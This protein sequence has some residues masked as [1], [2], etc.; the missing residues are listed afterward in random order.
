MMIGD[1]RMHVRGL[2]LRWCNNG[3]TVGSMPLTMSMMRYVVHGRQV[4][5]THASRVRPAGHREEGMNRLIVLHSIMRQLLT[6]QYI[7]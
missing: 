6:L 2:M 5:V 4:K 7:L 1:R 3:W